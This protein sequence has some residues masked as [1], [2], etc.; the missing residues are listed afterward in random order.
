MRTENRPTIAIIDRRNFCAAAGATAL[1]ALAPHSAAADTDEY[2][3]TDAGWTFTGQAGVQ[4]IGSGWLWQ[5]PMPPQGIQ[6]AFIQSD[7][8][9]INQSLIFSPG[10]YAIRFMAAQRTNG[11]DSNAG[12]E[13]INVYFDSKLIGSF[14]AL[15]SS[16]V[17]TPF[18][19]RSFKADGKSHIVSFKGTNSGDNT[20]FIDAVQIFNQPV[21]E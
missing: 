16:G 1:V 12:P 3:P 10:K 13:G 8:G 6:T 15:P 11:T 2:N 5:S 21:A 20:A 18:E 17:F 14:D 7:T 4:E 19:M 9:V